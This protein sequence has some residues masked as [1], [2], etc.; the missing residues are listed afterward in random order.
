MLFCIMHMWLN[1]RAGVS[2]VQPEGKIRLSEQFY[3]ARK[4]VKFV[5]FLQ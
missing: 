2:K 1:T 4:E 3:P 5:L